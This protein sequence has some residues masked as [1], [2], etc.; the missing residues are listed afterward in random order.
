MTEVRMVKNTNESKCGHGC[1]E[2]KHFFAVGEST[3]NSHFGNQC[4]H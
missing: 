3:E 4:F 2:G 1:G